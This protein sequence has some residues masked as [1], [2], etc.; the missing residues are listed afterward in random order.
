L[1]GY[2]SI[3]CTEQDNIF[4]FCYKFNKIVK[5]CIKRETLSKYTASVWLLYRLLFLVTEKA[6][7]KLVIDVKE[8]STIDYLT[9][10]KFA[11]QRARSNKSIK[12]IN[13]EHTNTEH[14]I[15]QL[16][17]KLQKPAMVENNIRLDNKED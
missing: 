15:N 2:K 14:W 3:L 12:Y 1:K 10:L 9:I 7:K 6:I 11:I 8:P 13:A 17:E 4:N 16:T 5:H